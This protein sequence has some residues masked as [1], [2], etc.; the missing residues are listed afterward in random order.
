MNKKLVIKVEYLPERRRGRRKM[1]AGDLDAW[2]VKYD[3]YPDCQEL[4]F[5]VDETPRNEQK[6]KGNPIDHVVLS[7]R[8][9]LSRAKKAVNGGS[10]S[11]K[12]SR[13]CVD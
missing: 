1:F 9:F 4:F 13:I 7:L 5:M 2:T 6:T 12:R 11:T 10:S 3:E 8:E